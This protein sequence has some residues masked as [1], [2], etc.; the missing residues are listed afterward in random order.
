VVDKSKT[1]RKNFKV[2]VKTGIFEQVGSGI[3]VAL[4]SGINKM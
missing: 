3:H 2:S 1:A 4:D